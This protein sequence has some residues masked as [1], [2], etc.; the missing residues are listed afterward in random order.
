MEDEPTT[1][2]GEN[3]EIHHGN[4]RDGGGG[5][6]VLLLYGGG[7]DVAER[8]DTGR[9]K[10][11]PPCAQ[12]EEQLN[13]HLLINLAPAGHLDGS[14]RDEAGVPLAAVAVRLHATDGTAR[15]ETETDYVGHWRIEGVRDGRY[16]LL[17][18]HPDRPL[19][20]AEDLVF[21]GPSQRHPERVLP[22]LVELVIRVV[23]ESGSP[24]P[25]A[26]VRGF[27]RPQ[28]AVEETTDEFGLARVRSAVAGDYN[29]RVLH[30]SGR[31]GK[32][33]FRVEVGPQVREVEILCQPR[34]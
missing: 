34:R 28:G 18:G 2:A 12:S 13:A 22:P 30:P 15:L 11:P 26:T 29:V 1:T 4:A 32:S 24:M 10:S 33:V 25:D 9:C 23:D 6:G 16:Q 20:P 19:L 17:F 14:V 5:A 8:H 7:V 27:V 21:V 31:Q 3:A